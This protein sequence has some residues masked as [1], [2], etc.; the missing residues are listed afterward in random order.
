MMTLSSQHAQQFVELYQSL[1]KTNLAL[2]ADIYHPDIIFIDPMHELN[3]LDELQ[4]YFANLYQNINSIEFEIRQRFEVNNH[5]ILYW[6]MTFSHPKLKNGKNIKVDGNSL[7]QF[8]AGLVTYHRDYFDSNA[9]LFE[10]IPVL[11]RLIRYIKSRA[12]Q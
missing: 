9:M 5:L 1:N 6:Q 12:T 10:H 3:G 7:V 11:G 4:V 2:L 8:H